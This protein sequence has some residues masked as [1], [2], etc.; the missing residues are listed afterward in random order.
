MTCGYTNITNV[1]LKNSLNLT[2]AK[3]LQNCIPTS[4]SYEMHNTVFIVSCIV[5][6]CIMSKHTYII[7]LYCY[8]TISISG[9]YGK[10]FI[11]SKIL[12]AFSPANMTALYQLTD[13]GVFAV[14]KRR[15]AHEMLA[16]LF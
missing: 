5:A 6:Y 4:S 8:L 14:L 9:W 12:I 3:V 10:I 1:K 2:F 13:Q 15:Y 16:Y 7:K 11:P